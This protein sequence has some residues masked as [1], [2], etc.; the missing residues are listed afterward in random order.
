MIT[1][2][3]MAVVLAVLSGSPTF[4]QDAGSQKFLKEAIEGNFAEVEMGKLAQKQGA[5][6]GVRAF[7]QMLEKD[8]SDAN[9]NATTVA[10][11]VGMTAPTAPNKKQKADYDKMSKLSGAK[12][13]KEFA[14]HMVADHKKDIKEYEKAAKKQDA[15]GNYAK[16]TLPTLRKHL[17]TAQS[18]NGTTST[19]NPA[20]SPAVIAVPAPAAGV[21][22]PASE[23]TR[24]EKVR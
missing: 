19:A 2:F 5:S 7:G 13:D 23:T 22:A 24:G 21:P 20:K 17:E 8:H 6:E 12:F 11:S 9:K 10:N 15:V 16:E 18:L 3:S 14:A 4:A 1:K